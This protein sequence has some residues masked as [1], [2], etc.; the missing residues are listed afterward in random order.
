VK[1]QG[2]VAS[3]RPTWSSVAGTSN[4]AQTMNVSAIAAQRGQARIRHV[5]A[6]ASAT[7]NPASTAV[8][9]RI[10]RSH[11]RSA[12]RTRGPRMPRGCTEGGMKGQGSA[13]SSGIVI[14]TSTP[15]VASSIQAL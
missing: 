7:S 13:P 8:E 4:I 14:A 11:S 10:P 9:R 5:A 2:A 6:A 12:T 15:S 3:R 1:Y